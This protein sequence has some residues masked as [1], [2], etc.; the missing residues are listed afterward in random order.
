MESHPGTNKLKMLEINWHIIKKENKNQR[1]RNSRMGY[2]KRTETPF[3]IYF[4]KGSKNVVEESTIILR[5]PG[6]GVGDA[7]IFLGFNITGNTDI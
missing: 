1:G 7:A 5:R 4:L 3:I 2:L 6:L